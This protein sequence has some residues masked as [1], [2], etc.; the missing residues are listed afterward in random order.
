MRPSLTEKSDLTFLQLIHNRRQVGQRAKPFASLLFTRI[1][2]LPSEH[3]F[4][5]IRCRIMGFLLFFGWLFL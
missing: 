1:S 3:L 4:G 5:A 2:A